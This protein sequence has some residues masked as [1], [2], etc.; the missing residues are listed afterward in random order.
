MTKQQ[1]IEKGGKAQ[2]ER[3]GKVIIARVCFYDNSLRRAWQNLSLGW[4]KVSSLIMGS[5]RHKQEKHNKRTPRGFSKTFVKNNKS[6]SQNLH[7]KVP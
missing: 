4:R 5:P 1:G 6:S 7:C 3:G 2:T